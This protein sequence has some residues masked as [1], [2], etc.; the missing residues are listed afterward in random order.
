MGSVEFAVA[1]FDTRLV[2]VLGH[3]QCGAVCATVEQLQRP[4]G[5]QSRNIRSIVDRIR[6]SVE[7]LLATELRHHPEALMQQAVRANVRAS[8]NHLRH[9]SELI[10]DLIEH[11]GLL[12]VGAEYSLATGVV[13]FLNG[14]QE[15]AS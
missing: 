7:G 14:D 5:D 10:E 8:V 13:D 3:S 15:T 9:G 1:Q 2:V 6:P 11:D 12:I 4:T